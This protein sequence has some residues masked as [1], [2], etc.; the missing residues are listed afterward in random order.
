MGKVL[1]VSEKLVT[2]IIVTYNSS[3]YVEATL[4]SAKNQTYKNIE[5]IVSD[6][7]SS[8][9]TI[10]I[11]EKWLLDNADSFV[12]NQLITSL[13]N[14][15]IPANCNRGVN[16]AKGDW[17]KL[18][19]GDDVLDVNCILN[20]LEFVKRSNAK[21]FFSDLYNLQ[22]DSVIDVETSPQIINFFKMSV[23]KKYRSFLRN[24]Y[25]LNIPT[26]FV[27]RNT[28]SDLGNF[29]E[30]FKYL[31]DMPLILK[32]L[33]NGYD[34]GYLNKKTVLRRIHEESISTLSTSTNNFR[35]EFLFNLYEVYRLHRRPY[36][37]SYNI[38]D[39]Y[40]KATNDLNFRD[41]KK[42]NFFSRSLYKARVIYSKI[43]RVFINE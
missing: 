28:L 34:I 16:A 7:G 15:G 12:F 4:E 8:D 37:S 1:D 43:K 2:I 13:N 36:L 5:L 17:I 39:V 3:K 31:E 9:N 41:Y 10:E 14:T 19:A 23:V 20:Y 33:K 27:N 18:I 22:N 24:A 6:D 32:F 40:S 25:F 30:R 11:C 38:L 26:I 21:L 35:K 29:D 42:P